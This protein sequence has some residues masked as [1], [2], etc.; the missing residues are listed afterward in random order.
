MRLGGCLL[1]SCNNK[2]VCVGIFLFF[3]DERLA[4]VVGFDRAVDA[5]EAIE[6]VPNTD[7][8]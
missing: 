5:F 2:C 3:A 4:F 7:L 1:H 6:G 8:I